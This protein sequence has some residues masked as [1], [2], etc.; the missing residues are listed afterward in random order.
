MPYRR[1]KLTFAISSPDEFLF[2]SSERSLVTV[3][4]AA[5]TAEEQ[6]YLTI[7]HNVNAPVITRGKRRRLWVYNINLRRPQQGDLLKELRSDENLF[8]MAFN[9]L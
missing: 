8:F 7:G 3:F 5:E 4:A 1:K 6:G 9:A 2:I